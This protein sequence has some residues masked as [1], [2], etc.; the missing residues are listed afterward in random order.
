MKK[1]SL[2]K[3]KPT[4]SSELA[5]YL[6]EAVLAEQAVQA[7][8]QRLRKAKAALKAAR[9]T[10]RR[11]KDAADETA[12]IAKAAKKYFDRHPQEPPKKQQKAKTPTPK[13][14]SGT[15][16]RPKKRAAAPRATTPAPAPLQPLAG[17][18]KES[19]SRQN[20]I[21]SGALPA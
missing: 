14:K 6:T 13:R 2:P 15:A 4:S 18:Q 8:K 10:H 12:K 17:E 21:G 16:Q 20:P 11:A 9:Q 3:P 7:S 1:P 5:R 19:S